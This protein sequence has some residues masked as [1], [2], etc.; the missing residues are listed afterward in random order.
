MKSQE[1]EYFI[2][3]IRNKCHS[4]SMLNLIVIFFWK[5]FWIAQY[6]PLESFDSRICQLVFQEFIHEQKQGVHEFGQNLE[7]NLWLNSHL[8]PCMFAR[9]TN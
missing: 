4:M 5:C 9:G 8:I 3:F 7:I 6:I 1:D 2:E